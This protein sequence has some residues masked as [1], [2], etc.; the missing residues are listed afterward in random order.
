M[1]QSKTELKEHKPDIVIKD[2]PLLHMTSITK[3]AVD[4][5]KA[6]SWDEIQTIDDLGFRVIARAIKDREGAH[7]DRLNRD[8]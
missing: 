4:R 1:D 2:T 6:A 7:N 5:I 8:E 3:D